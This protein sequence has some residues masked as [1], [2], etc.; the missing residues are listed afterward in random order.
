MDLA[1]FVTKTLV[2]I[3]TGVRDANIELKKSEIYA[4]EKDG[5]FR[6]SE[7]IERHQ[8]GVAFDVAVTVSSEGTSGKAGQVLSMSVVD[9]SGQLAGR[10]VTTGSM[11][12]QPPS[13]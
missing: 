12:E 9:C 3:S 7:G 5:P 4:R 13:G 2:D 1:T 11:A 10:R 8:T 6:L